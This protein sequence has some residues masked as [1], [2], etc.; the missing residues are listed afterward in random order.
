MGNNLRQ[1]REKRGFTQ[2]ELST[3]VGISRQYL[4]DI[5]TLKKQPTI[6]I[7][8]DCA[9]VLKVSIEELFYYI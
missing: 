5:E 7:A 8:F 6:K 4:S 3:A 1:F 9:R 2:T